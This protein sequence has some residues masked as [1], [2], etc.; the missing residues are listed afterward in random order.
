MK[1]YN[2]ITGQNIHRMEALSDGVF[3]IA[4]TLLVLDVRVPLSEGIN[5][6]KD[7]IAAFTKLSPRL[8]TY[9]LSFLTLGI[10]WMAHSSQF[11]VI[12]KSDRNLT[13]INLSF[14]LFVTITPFTTAFLSEYITFRFAV[15]LY[16][17]NLF[18]LGMMLFVNL[19]YVDK[20]N[21]F[22]S[23][24]SHINE[25]KSA[26]VRRGVIAQSLYAFGAL[27]SFVST[28]LSISV[29]LGIQIYFALGLFSKRNARTVIKKR[30]RGN[31]K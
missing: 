8:F 12:G 15:G 26:M 9:F 21:L 16:W 2:Q 28:Y 29:L 4:L 19:R 6:E 23:N 14:L 1:D 30:Y 17:L 13:W 24:F 27:L 31:A 25:F 7:L 18:L 10:F 5:Q 22:K 11:L 3:A 20:N